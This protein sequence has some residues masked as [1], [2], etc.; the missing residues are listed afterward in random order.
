MSVRSLEGTVEPIITLEA[1]TSL[2]RPLHYDN[3]GPISSN[4]ERSASM[5]LEGCGGDLWL[6][7]G[8]GWGVTVIVFEC[9]NI[10]KMDAM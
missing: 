5:C 7:R 8:G 4:L 1:F 2:Q 10:E 9:G 6:A 3:I